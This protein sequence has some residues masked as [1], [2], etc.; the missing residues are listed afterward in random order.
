MQG[1]SE[2]CPGGVQASTKGEMANMLDAMAPGVQDLLMGALVEPASNHNTPLH[3]QA[4]EKLLC[5]CKGIMWHSC[6]VAFAL[7][8]NCFGAWLQRGHV[9]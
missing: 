7:L 4:A 9:H 3:S 2:T 6:S 5:E 1:P 8:G